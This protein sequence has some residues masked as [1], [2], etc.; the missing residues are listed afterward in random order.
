MS[1][2]DQIIWKGDSETLIVI[3]RDKNGLVNLSTA[4]SIKAVM[5]NYAG[6]DPHEI[7]CSGN[8]QG[9]VIIDITGT[10]TANDGSYKLRIIVIISGKQYTFPSEGPIYIKIITF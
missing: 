4:T 3:L 5:N 1:E 7:E 2:Y 10:D 8:E 9:R 6:N